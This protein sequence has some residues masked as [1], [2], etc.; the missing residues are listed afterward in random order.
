M[1][2]RDESFV[3]ADGEDDTAIPNEISY[4][5]SPAVVCLDCF[6]DVAVTAREVRPMPQ[7][8]FPNI[9]LTLDTSSY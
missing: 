1:G 4:D 3:T 2:D 8:V 5:L 7:H 6:I 9:R